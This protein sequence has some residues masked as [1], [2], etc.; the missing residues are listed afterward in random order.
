MTKLVRT[1]SHLETLSLHCC[2]E[3]FPIDAIRKHGLSLR[4]LWLREYDG[5]VHRP[6]RQSR[7]PTLSLHALLEIQSFCPN[8]MELGLDL[9]QGMMVRSPP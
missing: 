7:V 2:V 6:L 1:I 4:H 5:I 3:E 8:A 9:D